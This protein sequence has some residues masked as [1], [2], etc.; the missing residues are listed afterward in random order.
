MSE[1]LKQKLAELVKKKIGQNSY[2]RFSDIISEEINKALLNKKI[3]ESLERKGK[4]DDASEVKKLIKKIKKRIYYSSR[5]FY[6]AEGEHVSILERG[7]NLTAILEFLKK[8]MI[9]KN[10]NT[11]VD[12]G[13]GTFPI[14]FDAFLGEASPKLRYYAI[15]KNKKIYESLLIYSK[16]SKMLLTPILADADTDSLEEIY[17]NINN[18]DKSLTL[19]L[20]ILHTLYRTKRLNLVEFIEK[21][22]S[23]YLLISEPKFSLVKKNDIS[24]KEKAFLLRLSNKL[25]ANGT[26][27]DFE[28]LDTEEEIFVLM[29]K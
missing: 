13:S 20:R 10:I 24:K 23:K 3:A 27:S 25:K 1:E 15:E 22:G 14:Y 11:I 5:V 18:Y 9:E 7:K 21:I 8:L 17:K 2:E 29:T 6:S 26:I 28:I 19:L 16:K 12:I 4:L